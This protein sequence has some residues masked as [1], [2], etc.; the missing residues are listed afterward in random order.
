M[1]FLCTCGL[2]KG[3]PYIAFLRCGSKAKR[4]FFRAI[5]AIIPAIIF[6]FLKEVTTSAIRKSFKTIDVK[7]LRFIGWQHGHCSVELDGRENELESIT[8]GQRIRQILMAG[9]ALV[10]EFSLANRCVNR[11]SFLP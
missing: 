2:G 6:G 9:V 5:L 10:T 3:E 4:N 11:C 8:I 7:P 1:S